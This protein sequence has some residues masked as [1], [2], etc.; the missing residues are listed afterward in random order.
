MDELEFRRRLYADPTDDAVLKAAE[1]SPQFKAE[2]DDVLTFEQAMQQ[3][4]EVPIPAGLA[5]RLMQHANEVAT[6]QA[7]QEI[8][9]KTTHKKVVQ[10]S[11][12]RRHLAPFA[13]AASIFVAMTLY[14]FSASPTG[15]H[16]NEYAFE[17]INHELG[18]FK[19]TAEVSID[20]V[21][22][23]LATFGA[24]LE[25]MPGKVTYAT[26]CNYL[27]KKSLH[28]IYQSDSGPVTVFFVPRDNSFKE[29]SRAFFNEQFSGLL[30]PLDKADVILV[31][32]LHS[33]VEQFAESFTR[34]LTWL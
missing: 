9:E 15:V 16:A 17:H 12:Y 19:Y 6:E 18:A 8:S 24:K 3:S 4:I 30:S 26:Y 34:R 14:L 29:K 22:D 10:L 33:P 31:A 1:Q 7:P 25:D 32:N 5:E 23:K 27:G 20:K 11:W 13:M 28:L 21:N 2:L